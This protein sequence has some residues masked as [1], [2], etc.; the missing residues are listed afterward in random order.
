MLLAAWAAAVSTCAFVV[1]NSPRASSTDRP[2]N[3]AP[4]KKIGEVNVPPPVPAM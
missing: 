3:L 2:V 1:A 4:A